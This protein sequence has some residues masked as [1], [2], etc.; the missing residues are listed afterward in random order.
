MSDERSY[1][2]WIKPCLDWIISIGWLNERILRTRTMGI[3]DWWRSPTQDLDIK[4]S[5]LGWG[6][7]GTVW[8]VYIFDNRNS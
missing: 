2:P 5:V 6:K 1:F 7:C 8:E 3:S 4:M